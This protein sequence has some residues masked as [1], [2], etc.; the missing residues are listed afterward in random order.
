[1]QSLQS[2]C[3]WDRPKHFVKLGSIQAAA[4]MLDICGLEQKAVW[5]GSFQ[6]TEIASLWISHAEI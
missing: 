1:M 5:E 6:T 4:W 3:R 2:L